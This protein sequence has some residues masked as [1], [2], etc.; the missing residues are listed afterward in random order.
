MKLG[1][2]ELLGLLK[3][4]NPAVASS[5][6]QLLELAHIWFSGT[7]VSAFD[8]LLGIKIE[9]ET[10]FTGGVLGEKLIGVLERSRARDV[11]IGLDGDDLLMKIGAARIKLTRRPIEDW[12]WNPEIPKEDGF[13][14]T[15]SFQQAVD[16][17]LLSVGASNVLNP[18]QRGITIIQNGKA[19]DLYST[20]AVSLSW[21]QVDTTKQPVFNHSNRL[22]IPTPFCQQVK[23]LKG[24]AELRFDENAVY[25]LT[26]ITLVEGSKKEG[27]ERKAVVAEALIFSK[28]VEDDNPVEFERLVKQFTGGDV[29]LAIEVPG[30]LKLRAER[31]MVLLG[32]QPAELS[33][34]EGHLYLYA[35]TPYGEVDDVLKIESTHPD[36]KAKIDVALLAR[37]LDV[38]TKISITKQSLVLTGP[39][40]LVHV[41]ACK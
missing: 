18:E 9:F 1:R 40:N 5:R 19:A 34:E 28:L 3:A 2:A 41:V 14:I 13:T 6:N 11:D 38:C 33:V 32:D 30:Q 20:D 10:E 39:N 31:A 26:S 4:L 35:Q 8:D 16:M 7:H 24:E 17:A 37:A 27:E 15:K 21:V 23:S 36:V 29:E 12:F 25:C 22:I